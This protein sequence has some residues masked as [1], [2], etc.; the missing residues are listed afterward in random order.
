MFEVVAHKRIQLMTTVI[1]KKVPQ[2]TYHCK[3]ENRK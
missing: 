3:T 1:H 2:M